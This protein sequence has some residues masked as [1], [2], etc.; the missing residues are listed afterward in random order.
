[1][2]RSYDGKERPVRWRLPPVSA[3]YGWL[4][5]GELLRPREGV[6]GYATTFV[7]AKAG[8]RA[9]RKVTL[10]A[11]AA[12]AFRVYWNGEAVLEDPGYRELD[13]DRFATTVT[14]QPGNN[15]VT[16]KV[17]GAD[18]SPKLALRVGDERGEPDPGIEVPADL[19]AAAT[20]PVPPSPTPPAKPAARAPRTSGP[21]GPMQIFERMVSGAKPPPA[22]LEALR[23]LPRHHR[24]RQPAGAPRA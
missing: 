24:R 19:L 18:E 17:C 2:S 6:C 11:G 1:M 23:P 5:L 7:A 14:L 21:E 22:A 10:W 4:D 16:V 9:P 15:R 12:G 13:I 3:A 8:T 20:A